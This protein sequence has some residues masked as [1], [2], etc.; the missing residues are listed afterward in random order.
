MLVFVYFILFYFLLRRRYSPPESPNNIRKESQ[1]HAAFCIANSP[2]KW[3][4]PFW[5]F[6]FRICHK[7]YS[8]RL[9]EISRGVS[10]SHLLLIL[11]SWLT[12]YLW[13]VLT[14][15][16]IRCR[17]RSWLHCDT[18]RVCVYWWVK[19]MFILSVSNNCFIFNNQ[20]E[21]IHKFA[22][23]VY[24]KSIRKILW[25]CDRWTPLHLAAVYLRVNVFP[26]VGKKS[27]FKAGCSGGISDFLFYVKKLFSNEMMLIPLKWNWY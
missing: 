9:A 17:Q 3:M 1:L 21:I 26:T 7:T 15:L 8:M 10:F 23:H 13:M 5:N 2:L 16:L 25:K 14:R 6:C 27:P 24:L 20:L 18:W 11:T 4:F 19:M 12:A 22:I